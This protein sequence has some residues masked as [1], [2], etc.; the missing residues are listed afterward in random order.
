MRV[1]VALRI[2]FKM[3][4]KEYIMFSGMIFALVALVHLFRMIY[5]LPAVIGSWEVPM[6]VSALAVV[7]AGFLAWKAQKLSR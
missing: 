3:K 6:W 2:R 1:K 7:L 4:Q 5:A